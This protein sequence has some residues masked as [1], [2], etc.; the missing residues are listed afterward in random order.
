[1]KNFFVLLL[2]FSFNTSRGVKQDCYPLNE[3]D[4]CCCDLIDRG[5][6]QVGYI[7]CNS[8]EATEIPDGSVNYGTV[9]HIFINGSSIT[10][11][12]TLY[13]YYVLVTV[14]V[15]RNVGLCSQVF[16]FMETQPNVNVRTDCQITTT[17]EPTTTTTTTTTSAAT[18]EPPPTTT[19][20]MT[21]TTLDVLTE[22]TAINTTFLVYMVIYFTG[23]PGLF[24]FDS[25][26]ACGSIPTQVP[27]RF[28]I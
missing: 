16:T 6:R 28:Y 25:T 3:C 9:N 2:C 23:T 4:T 19:A 27:V 18:T 8:L 24:L 21:F 12:T 15:H 17:A 20:E 5:N 13:N 7:I 1:M 11:L 22:Y 26:G 14:S 10:D